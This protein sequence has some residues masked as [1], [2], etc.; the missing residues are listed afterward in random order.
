MAMS[1]ARPNG[2]D[3]GTLPCSVDGIASSGLIR[4]RDRSIT[5]GLWSMANGAAV[6]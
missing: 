2:P 3:R 5:F 1:A 6:R 4:M